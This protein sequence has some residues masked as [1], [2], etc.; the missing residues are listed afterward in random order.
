MEMETNSG[1]GKRGR[2]KS[3]TAGLSGKEWTR[4][5]SEFGCRERRLTS[6]RAGP[7]H[8]RF[9]RDTELS[10]RWY[11][12]ASGTW[13]AG[14]R[15]ELSASGTPACLVSGG[16]GCRGCAVPVLRVLCVAVCPPHRVPCFAARGMNSKVCNPPQ[17][18]GVSSS[19]QPYRDKGLD[20]SLLAI[21]KTASLE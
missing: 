18:E 2:K 15:A 14:R 10:G 6:G 20:V 1:T 17:P 8:L 12:L 4:L 16:L 9:P 7:V 21:L 13:G 19:G 5:S 11:P 3:R